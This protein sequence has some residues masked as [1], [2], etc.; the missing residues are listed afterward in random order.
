MLEPLLEPAAPSLAL[1]PRLLKGAIFELLHARIIAG[2]YAAGEWLRQE[3]IATQLGVSMTPV[4][5]ALDLLVSAGL[6]ERIP[7]RGVRVLQLTPEEIADS[8]YLR[9]LLECSAARA[10]A[11][12]ITPAQVDELERLLEQ[13]NGLVTLNEISS[14]RQLNRQFHIAVAAAAGMPLLTRTYETILNTFPDWMLY[15]YMFR[16]PE[17]LASSLEQEYAEHRALVEALGTHNP[18]QAAFQAGQHIINRAGELET[19]LNIPHKL[20][21]QRERQIRALL[22]LEKTP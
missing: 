12:A 22:G 6:A 10:A 8:Y 5:E 20:L 16:H 1:Q 4:R 13:M 2:K 18:D 19:Y 15:E 9:L 11:Q 17:L 21:H 14:Q 3:E 7:Y